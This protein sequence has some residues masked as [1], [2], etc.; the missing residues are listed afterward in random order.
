[1]FGK[2]IMNSIRKYPAKYIAIAVC[3]VVLLIISLFASCV[4]LEKLSDP[5]GGFV[6]LALDYSFSFSKLVGMS[7][8][9]GSKEAEEMIAADNAN[10]PN[11]TDMRER[12]YDFCNRSPIKIDYVGITP[13]GLEKNYYTSRI[14]YF[15]TYENLVYYFTEG[16]KPAWSAPKNMLPTEQQYL[17]KEKVV[18]LGMGPDHD[19][20][21]EYVYSDE[22][23]LLIGKNDD[24]YLIVGTSISNIT[25]MFF[26]TEP[27]YLKL[28]DIVFTFAEYPTQ[29]QIDE[30]TALFKETVAP[31]IEI[32]YS[33]PP[34]IKDLLEKRKEIS[35]IVVMSALILI[36]SFNILAIFKIMADERK[37]EY[38]VFRLCGYG[39]FKAMLFPFAEIISLSAVCAVLS[40]VIF[41]A[42]TP[43][44]KQSYSV[45]TVMFDFG[46]YA[47]FVLG[48]VAVTA[49]LFAVYILPSLN[50][51]V[52]DELRE[53]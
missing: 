43:L 6:N 50:K 11:I 42:L 47:V 53:M 15:P 7:W 37:S 34:H 41:I 27:D 13:A 17:N 30:F 33:D 23:H 39:K 25:Y 12:I 9:A 16:C 36:S 32:T 26:G 8:P 52:S 3:E 28:S 40:C 35:N 24:E 38:A 51:S 48:F 2:Y 4:L 44:I 31:D 49:V 45:V 46:F 20:H 5:G 10:L 19:S 29:K 1:M 18:V 14:K 21:G 22:N